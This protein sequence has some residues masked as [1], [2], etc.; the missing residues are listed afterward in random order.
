MI[1]RIKIKTTTVSG[2]K[3]DIKIMKEVKVLW[4]QDCIFN[5]AIFCPE[6]NKTEKI[7]DS[8][9]SL[10]LFMISLALTQE[11]IFLKINFKY[12]FSGFR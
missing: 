9:L 12:N 10:L 3:W 7:K 6:T 8:E 11:I 4:H 1:S 2:I 5:F